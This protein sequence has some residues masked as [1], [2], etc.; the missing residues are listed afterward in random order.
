MDST[1]TARATGAGG[2]RLRSLLRSAAIAL[3]V[4]SI[5]LPGGAGAWAAYLQATG[6]IHEVVPGLL[7]RSN[8]L[9]PAQLRALLQ[10]EGI[11]TV[12]N[13]RGGSRQDAWYR[14]EADVV[15][16]ADARLVDIPIAD[17]KEPDIA[18]IT[19]LLAALRTS[20][21]PVLIHCKAGADRTG[22][23]AALY[24]LEVAGLPPEVAARQL[25]FAFG[26]FPW[27]GSQT[28]AM[29]R[30]FWGFVDQLPGAT[31]S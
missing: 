31:E 28:G 3:I 25:S 19:R 5:V 16:G 18:S 20:P 11:R 8:Q 17:D 30:A 12:I 7:Y 21:T 22:L 24:L 10:D 4:S 6:N 29:D 26:H 2:K 23:A 14:E 27:L 1:T 15:A 13:L 9:G